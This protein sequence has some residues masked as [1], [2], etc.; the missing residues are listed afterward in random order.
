MFRTGM[1]TMKMS[2][3]LIFFGVIIQPITT[4][5]LNV[6]TERVNIRLLNMSNNQV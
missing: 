1:I 2:H 5:R 4:F 3:N 6:N